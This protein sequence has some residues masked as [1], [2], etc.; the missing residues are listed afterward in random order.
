MPVLYLSSNQWGGTC[1][2]ELLL[3]WL[4]Q[5][6]IQS[7]V[8]SIYFIK[9]LSKIKIYIRNEFHISKV[10]QNVNYIASHAK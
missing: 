5:L 6:Y 1:M 2:L 8:L 9:F 3:C 7:Q 10:Y 4:L